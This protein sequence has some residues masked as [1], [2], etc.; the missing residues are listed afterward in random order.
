M[1]KADLVWDQSVF[2]WDSFW[3]SLEVEIWD[4]ASTVGKEAILSTYVRICLTLPH[5][6]GLKR[7]FAIHVLAMTCKVI[8][9]E[10][11]GK[12]VS[13]LVLCVNRENLDKSLAYV[14]T[15]VMVADIDMFRSGMKLGE[16]SQFQSTRV[17][18]KDLTVDVGLSTNDL[19][20]SFLHFRY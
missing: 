15:K 1:I 8:L 20:I 19:K 3:D 17:V 16:S 13:N 12:C 11:L 9:S 5:I 4:Q 7:S 14:F 18:L 10:G 6:G 2:K